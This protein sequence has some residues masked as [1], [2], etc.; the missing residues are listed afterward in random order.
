MLNTSAEQ[1]A[2]LADIQ[3]PM[4]PTPAARLKVIHAEIPLG[5][6]KTSFDRPTR[7]RHPQ[8]PFQRDPGTHGHVGDE[9]FDFVMVEYVAGDDQ[10]MART[11]QAGRAM[12]AVKRRVFDLPNDRTF[13][14]VF[15][16]ESLPLLLLKLTRIN[17]Q[18]LHFTGRKCLSRQSRI[19]PFSPTF[20]GFL[21]PGAMQNPRLVNPASKVRWHL[22][23]ITLPQG[24]KPVEELTIPAILFVKCPSRYTNSVAHRP[25]NLL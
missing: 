25:A 10:S 9:V 19:S 15:D 24:V 7:E 17:Q 13:L 8:H 18:V 4:N 12:L 21:R 6:F 11:G 3:M 20:A 16:L 5:Q 1:Q 22:A 23:N 14:A 2:Q